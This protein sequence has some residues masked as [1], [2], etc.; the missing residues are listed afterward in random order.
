LAPFL[1]MNQPLA[2]GG[3][4]TGFQTTGFIGRAGPHLVQQPKDT[5]RRGVL[6][7]FTNVCQRWHITYREQI[8]LL[9]YKDAEW[10]GA[11]VLLASGLDIPQ[12]AK[13]RI[14]YM[15]SISLGLGGLFREAID[16]ERAWLRAPKAALR[17][18]TPLG[19]MLGGRMENL[20]K[21]LDLV[22]KERGL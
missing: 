13:D 6:E 16:A 11:Q 20:I 18:E 1:G 21:V 22:E 17:Q 4:Y 19:F 8:I 5:V 10:L 14:G 3:G 12:D 9:G 7:A 2:V 15:T